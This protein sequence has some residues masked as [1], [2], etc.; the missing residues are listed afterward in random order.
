M[1]KTSYVR[2]QTSEVLLEGSSATVQII[3]GY[4]K[5]KHAADLLAKVDMFARWCEEYPNA[6]LDLL[7]GELT[8]LSAGDSRTD[9]DSKPGAKTKTTVKKT[10]G[11]RKSGREAVVN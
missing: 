1:P 7:K 8:S 5:P 11:A 9:P 10:P 6:Q 4:E 3:V 2:K